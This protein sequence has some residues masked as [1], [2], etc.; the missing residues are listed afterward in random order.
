MESALTELSRRLLGTADRSLLDQQLDALCKRIAD[1]DV[2]DVLTALHEAGESDTLRDVLLDGRLTRWATETCTAREE[3]ALATQ[4]RKWL[5][6][7]SA[8]GDDPA[9]LT[10]IEAVPETAAGLLAWADQHRLT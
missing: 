1:E 8:A 5:G 10:P 4:L 7:G 6:T 2:R 9:R 3:D